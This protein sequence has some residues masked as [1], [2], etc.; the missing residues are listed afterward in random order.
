MVNYITVVLIAKNADVTIK[1]CLNNL[2][3][4]KEVVLY[5]NNS[6]DKT[7][8]IASVFSNVKIVEG[9]FL[10]F[11]PT[12]NHAASFSTNDWILSLD[13]DEILNDKLID[14][15]EK[16]DYDDIKKIYF[17]NRDNYFLDIKTST[18]DFIARIYNKKHTKL[19]DNQVH[20]KVIIN[21]NSTTYTLKNTF[22]HYNITD[23]NQTLTKMIQY[24]DLGAKDKR[25]C[26]FTIII[27]RSTFAFFKKYILKLHILDGWRGFVISITQANSVFYKYLKQ[28]INC[29]NK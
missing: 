8:E 20:E 6:T 24:T 9:E 26:S 13:T 3:R 7:K 25:M 21:D 12:K 16:Q 22:K 5:L 1:E 17:L 4:F 23:I 10:G 15:I 11:G 28:Y 2:S 18:N 27:I 14:E 29:Q 19:N